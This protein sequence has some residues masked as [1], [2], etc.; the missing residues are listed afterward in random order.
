MEEILKNIGFKEKE[1]SV[2]VQLNKWSQARAVNLSVELNFPKSTVIEILYKLEKRGFVSKLRRGN[3]FIFHAESPE[4]VI[5]ALDGKI[6]E[7]NALKK[8]ADEVVKQLITQRKNPNIPNVRYFNGI[9]GIKALY[10]DTLTSQGSI[11]AYGNFEAETDYIKSFS[12]DYWGRRSNAK[13]HLIGLIPDTKVNREMSLR[14]NKKH[15]RVTYLYDKKYMTPLEIDVY[16]DKIAIM[17]FKESFGILIKSKIISEALKN[18]INMAKE[19]K[20]KI[21]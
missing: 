14:T 17:S 15:L 1:I 8:K 13:I 18:I 6:L 3:Y 4:K 12:E 16:D 21:V 11:F 2:Y 5:S 20:E 19:G 9:E 7:L 10:E